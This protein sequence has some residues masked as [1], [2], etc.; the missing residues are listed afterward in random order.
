MCCSVV[1]V[2]IVMYIC[3]VVAGATDCVVG[4]ILF[5][6]CDYNHV[7]INTIESR[8]SFSWSFPAFWGWREKEGHHDT[9]VEQQHTQERRDARNA[10]FEILNFEFSSLIHWYFPPSICISHHQSLIIYFYKSNNKM[11]YKQKRFYI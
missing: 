10:T 9:L 4:C 2:S 6:S 8:D 1:A 7:S 3:C 5:V 11:M